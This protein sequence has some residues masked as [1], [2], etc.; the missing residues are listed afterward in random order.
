MRKLRLG[1]LALI[2]ALILCGWCNWLISLAN[3]VA[4][5]DLGQGR[6]ITIYAKAG[7]EVNRPLLFQIRDGLT[8]VKEGCLIEADVG[9]GS[10]HKFAIVF[11]DNRSLVGL[12]DYALGP[13][14]LVMYDFSSTS[15][16]WP[17]DI[18]D[19]ERDILFKRLQSENPGLEKIKD[20]PPFF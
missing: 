5:L 15:K 7:W 11:A 13:Q 10:S 17:C 3:T 6:S 12:V 18:G 2:V 16:V 19:Q 8:G 20:N 9:P 14:L 1:L 4:T